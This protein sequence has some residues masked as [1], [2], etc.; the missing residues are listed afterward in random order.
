[1]PPFR[2]FGLGMD[3]SH[4]AAAQPHATVLQIGVVLCKRDVAPLQVREEQCC[5]GFV[6]QEGR[7]ERE[8]SWQPVL[9]RMCLQ[10]AGCWSTELRCDSKRRT[11]SMVAQNISRLYIN[12]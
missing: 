5:L 9:S 1:M 3:S 10:S 2:G 4:L 7:V 8:L 6:W 11:A 12:I